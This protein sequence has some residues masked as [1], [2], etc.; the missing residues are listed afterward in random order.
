[1]KLLWKWLQS[2][3]QRLF[4]H[5]HLFSNSLRKIDNFFKTFSLYDFLYRSL[6]AFSKNHRH[7][8]MRQVWASA[9]TEKQRILGKKRRGTNP[10]TRTIRWVWLR[11]GSV[12]RPYSQRLRVTRG[13]DGTEPLI[14]ARGRGWACVTA[15]IG[16]EEVVSWKLVWRMDGPAGWWNL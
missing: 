4:L 1:M 15:L 6:C 8:L 11:T 10:T 7:Q 9:G 3:T 12:L 14:S 5:K 13:E 2:N 16:R